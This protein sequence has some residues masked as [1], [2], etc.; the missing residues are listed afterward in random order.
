MLRALA[1]RQHGVVAR[2]PSARERA[3]A[4]RRLLRFTWADVTQ[5]RSD[6]AATVRGALALGRRYPPDP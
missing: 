6:T 4:G 2:R 1:A 3:G 5:W